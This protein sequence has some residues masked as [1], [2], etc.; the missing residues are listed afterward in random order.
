[1]AEEFNDDN[2]KD[3]SGDNADVKESDIMDLDDDGEEVE[4]K[5]LVKTR[6]RKAEFLKLFPKFHL[7]VSSTCKHM[8][9]AQQTFYRWYNTD[10][11]FV[12]KVES[13]RLTTNMRVKDLLMHKVEVMKETRAITYFLDRKHPE[14]KPTSK[15]E[16]V[17][18]S[19]TLEDILKADEDKINDGRDNTAEQSNSEGPAIPVG[20]TVQNKDEETS[21]SA[22]DIQQGSTVLL[23]EKDKTESNSESKTK[24][25]VENH[26]RGP[27]PRLHSERY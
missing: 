15:T 10:E 21:V 1:M 16:V 12:K 20:E 22:A 9:I 17:T 25:L 4:K 23:E 27:A 18:G 7:V 8:N 26:R 5:D 11:D 6:A 14:F 3:E 2:T 13:A 24:G 19:R